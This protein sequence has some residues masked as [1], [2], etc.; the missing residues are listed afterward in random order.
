MAKLQAAQNRLY[1]NL[2]LC[3]L[4]LSQKFDLG[5]YAKNRWN[6]NIPKV[7]DNIII[8]YEKLK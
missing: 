7:I 8:G 6:E 1:K 4:E 3:F 5:K 2:F